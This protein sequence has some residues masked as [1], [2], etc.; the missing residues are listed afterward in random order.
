M[1]G[2]GANRT[3][4]RALTNFGFPSNS[5]PAAAAASA[6]VAAR[7]LM[8]SPVAAVAGNILDGAGNILDDISPVVAIAAI[9]PGGINPW[10]W[11][12]LRIRR[13]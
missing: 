5:V 2:M 1:T 10:V 8:D 3:S 12:F 4:C 6:D 11:Q 9:V 13:V 7:K